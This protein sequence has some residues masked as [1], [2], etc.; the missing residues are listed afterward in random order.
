MEGS[1]KV[2]RHF[3]DTENRKWKSEQVYAYASECVHFVV[4][5]NKV[6]GTGYSESPRKRKQNVAV[7][8]LFHA[9]RVTFVVHTTH[10]I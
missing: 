5:P 3:R 4:S 6:H 2:A 7:P 10:I 9:G 8:A 1:G